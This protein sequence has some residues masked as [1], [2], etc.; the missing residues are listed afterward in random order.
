ME[1]KQIVLT[2]LRRLAVMCCL[3]LSYSVMA[4]DITGVRFDHGG[5]LRL[6]KSAMLECALT[7]ELGL[8][9][10]GW[11]NP[12]WQDKAD[13]DEATS[14]DVVVYRGALTIG[15]RSLQFVQ[16]SI[17][18]GD[19]LELQV[20]ATSRVN[21]AS[22]GLYWV[23]SVDATEFDGGKA[24]IYNTY[25]T[26]DSLSFPEKPVGKTHVL[27]EV[28]A[29]GIE[30]L[31]STG[32]GVYVGFPKDLKIEVQDLRVHQ[33]NRFAVFIP[34]ATGNLK[35]GQNYNLKLS[36]KLVENINPA[37]LQFTVTPPDNPYPFEGF[38][39]NYC[40]QLS[41]PVTS[42][43]L[44]DLH[45]DRA[46]VEMSLH[47]WEPENDNNSADVADEKYYASRVAASEELAEEFK[48]AKTLADK[49]VP[50]MISVW[51]LPQWMYAGKPSDDKYIV[52]RELR[53]GIVPE[54]VESIV[55][56]LQYLKDKHGVEPDLFSLNEPDLGIYVVQ[57]AQVHADY[58]KLLGAALDKAGLKTKIVLG[59]NANAARC[60]EYWMPTL[61]DAQ[62]RRYVGAV[63][64][65]TWGVPSIDT[66]KEIGAASEKYMLP[67]IL[68][69]VGT[70]PGAYKTLTY[71]NYDYA[72]TELRLF[73]NLL[74]YSRA[75]ALL[76]WEFTGDYPLL[77][78]EKDNTIPTKRYW[79]MRQ[80]C[81]WL[82]QKPVIQKVVGGN[83]D[84]S[85]VAISGENGTMTL[86]L[87]NFL[88]RP[89][90]VEVRGVGLGVQKLLGVVT[91]AEDNYRLL[92]SVP[93]EFGRFK[94]VLP[95]QSLTTLSKELPKFPLPDKSSSEPAK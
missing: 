51:H 40:F 58:I 49:G 34:I 65:H 4:A 38:G 83:S 25:S 92:D 12:S 5:H 70:D 54:M 84:V 47:L 59:D 57:T 94:M 82:P 56:Y 20:N 74:K 89:V 16:S 55:T 80:Y 35:R 76:Y 24:V 69:E 30:L 6:I 26:T 1:K 42:R 63:S 29:R 52:A 18:K 60:P 81:N 32:N 85:M 19:T 78:L 3:I 28:Y 75:T 7:S 17:I 68:A 21:S 8:Y 95:P 2:R 36:L 22:E 15:K 39:G 27:K 93:V 31:N 90:Q 44:K 14:A 41:S 48:M 79:L 67:L 46:R 37:P 64:Y 13:R 71:H 66:M 72:M 9:P 23:F 61:D 33:K 11:Q 62:A 88:G 45:S 77:K 73:Q 87:A 53:K 91:S 50:L 10:K 86:H 43:T